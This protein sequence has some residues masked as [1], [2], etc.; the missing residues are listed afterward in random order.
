ML[1]IKEYN[2]GIMFIMFF[3]SNK[4]VGFITS[5]DVDIN[6]DLNQSKFV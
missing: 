2:S 1:A 4:F 6:D 5:K 3:S